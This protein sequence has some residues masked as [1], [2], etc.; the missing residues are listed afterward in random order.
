MFVVLEQVPA[1]TS[2][3]EDVQGAHNRNRLRGKTMTR[4]ASDPAKHH[5]TSP[6]F[7]TRPTERVD[8]SNFATTSLFGAAPPSSLQQKQSLQW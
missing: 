7:E 4:E 3:L 2:L 1:G 8:C 5:I 6:R